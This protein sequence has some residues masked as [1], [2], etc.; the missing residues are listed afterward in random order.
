MVVTAATARVADMCCV[1]VRN[2]NNNNNLI[3]LKRRVKAFNET[4]GLSLAPRGLDEMSFY[5]LIRTIVG[6]AIVQGIGPDPGR[7]CMR[8]CTPR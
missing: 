6:V 5:A 7:A 2:N 3:G 8:P 1:S 4:R